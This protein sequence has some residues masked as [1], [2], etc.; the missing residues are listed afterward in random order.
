M[1]QKFEKFHQKPPSLHNSATTVMFHWEWIIKARWN[2]VSTK[3]LRTHLPR[4]HIVHTSNEWSDS[5]ASFEDSEKIV[6][7][8]LARE[9]PGCTGK[10]SVCCSQASF[11][12]QP[13]R[14]THAVNCFASTTLGPS[15]VIAFCGGSECQ[16]HSRV[17]RASI[18][19]FVEGTRK[20]FA[21]A[22]SSLWTSLSFATRPG[23]EGRQSRA[24]WILFEKVYPSL[25]SWTKKILWAFSWRHQIIEGTYMRPH[26]TVPA[27]YPHWGSVSVARG[28][29]I[30]PHSASSRKVQEHCPP[31][32]ECEPGSSISRIH[33]PSCDSS[34]YDVSWRVKQPL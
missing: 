4:W 33:L 32:E 21:V 9:T 1:W 34:W 19:E 10:F 5:G 26:T 18:S 6:F 13:A 20:T 7:F 11:R 16:I 27:L 14:E 28:Q 17:E 24:H 15:C 31:F 25:S 12:P 2:L 23:K 8:L 29:P 22:K 3:H 30:Y